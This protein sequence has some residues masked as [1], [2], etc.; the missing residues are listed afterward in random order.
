[1]KNKTLFIFF[2]LECVLLGGL[3]FWYFQDYNQKMSVAISQYCYDTGPSIVINGTRTARGLRCTTDD[4]EVALSLFKDRVGSQIKNIHLTINIILFIIILLSNIILTVV[5]VKKHYTLYS[6]LLWLAYVV[7]L[8]PQS[9]LK[10]WEGDII[11][12]S[13]DSNLIIF[14]V[15]AILFI[16]S[17][18]HYGAIKSTKYREISL[19]AGIIFI[20]ILLM[21]V[22]WL[23][24][25]LI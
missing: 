16:Q 15:I 13:Q 22:G 5:S 7:F 21:L 14:F 3:L 10:G 18:L 1:M 24:W 4:K 9:K 23:A 6:E 25:V 19:T 11:P 2:L 12:Q 20:I 8:W 17:L